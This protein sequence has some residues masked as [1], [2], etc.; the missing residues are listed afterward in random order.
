MKRRDALKFG[1][2]AAPVVAIAVAAPLASAST[3]T[4]CANFY[5]FTPD[6]NDH[7]NKVRVTIANG[8]VTFTI[9]KFVDSVDFNIHW[10]STSSFNHHP[11]RAGLVGETFAFEI[12]N[13][14]C[15]VKWIQSH[16]N[17]MYYYGKGVF[18]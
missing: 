12:P 10:T 6:E 13:G 8:L 18:R 1:A 2:W 11:N 14:E 15:D 16:G 4:K 3:P 7:N 5:D 17:N 9:M